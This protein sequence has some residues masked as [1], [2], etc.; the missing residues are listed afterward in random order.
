MQHGNELSAPLPKGV[1]VNVPGDVAPFGKD[2]SLPAERALPGTL[3][4]N[5]E[6]IRIG[7]KGYW[8]Q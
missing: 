2:R 3:T 4:T 6:T 5:A 1:R 7:K 8:P